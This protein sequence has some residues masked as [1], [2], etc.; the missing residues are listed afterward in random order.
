MRDLIVG[1]TSSSVGSALRSALA[2]SSKQPA[3]DVG[4]FAGLM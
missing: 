4:Q 1:G 3:E 2:G